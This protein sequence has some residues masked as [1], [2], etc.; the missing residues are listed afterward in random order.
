MVALVYGLRLDEDCD[1]RQPGI[2]G[3]LTGRRLE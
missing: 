1:R 2:A 3:E